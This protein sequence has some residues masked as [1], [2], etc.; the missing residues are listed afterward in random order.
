MG[1]L[2]TRIRGF[3]HMDQYVL[4]HFSTEEEAS[5]AFQSAERFVKRMKQLFEE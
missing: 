3:R 5:S 4:E 1:F 2:L